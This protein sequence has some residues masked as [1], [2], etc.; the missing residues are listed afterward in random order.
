MGWLSVHREAGTSDKEWFQSELLG[1]HYRIEDCATVGSAFY[2]ICVPTDGREEP[3]AIMAVVLVTRTR[4]YYNFTYKDMDESVGP[5][6]SSCPERL[7]ARLGELVP[8][9]PSE[10]AKEW[11]ERCHAEIATK[12]RARLV[13]HGTIVYF[14][15]ALHYGDGVAED[16]FVFV[17]RSTFRRVTDRR[18]V[19][20]P[21]WR[22]RSDWSFERRPA[23]ATC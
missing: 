11:R 19:K 8:E 7:L 2:A 20:I 13:T 12:K 3:R 18:L 5:C 14:D 22:S 21:S 23:L 1:E 9:P 17:E 6:E 16:E 4:G 10:Y 15:E